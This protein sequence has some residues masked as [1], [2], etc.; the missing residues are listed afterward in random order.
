[1]DEEDVRVLTAVTPAA[2]AYLQLLIKRH[3]NFYIFSLDNVIATVQ[4]RKLRAQTR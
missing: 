4:M 3:P 2:T 1:M